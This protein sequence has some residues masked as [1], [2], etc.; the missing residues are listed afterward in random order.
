MTQACHAGEVLGREGS[1]D[2]LA[3]AAC[4]SATP[5]RM[6]V[7]GIA[8]PC[9]L[10]SW[11]FQPP[12][13]STGPLEPAAPR[14]GMQQIAHGSPGAV[15]MPPDAGAAA[16]AGTGE[17]Q[18]QQLL[19]ASFAPNAAW[20]LL[21]YPASWHLLRRSDAA[22]AAYVPVAACGAPTA[23]PVASPGRALLW[24]GVLLLERAGA[25]P[26]RVAA[27]D[28]ASCVHLSGPLEQASV[29][30]PAAAQPWHLAQLA[31]DL[32]AAV[33]GTCQLG[34]QGP[35]PAGHPAGG[36]LIS[37]AAT[38][39]LLHGDHAGSLRPLARQ[40][41]DTAEEQQLAPPNR[42]RTAALAVGRGAPA[43]FVQV[44]LSCPA[45]ACCAVC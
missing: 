39:A 30:L 15:R 35:G 11:A 33:P 7:L 12:G 2:L 18:Q 25:A 20:L 43:S 28:A 10:V 13:A 36:L 5:E 44:R 19:S 24:Q 3:V 14:P 45:P 34:A 38:G 23:Q 40:P 31:G 4:T 8:R 6:T 27:W 26:P 9:N 21:A 17:Q 22:A 16:V 41:Q 37:L 42:A 32:L 29:Q 1:P